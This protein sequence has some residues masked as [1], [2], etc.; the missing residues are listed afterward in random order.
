MTFKYQNANIHYTKSGTGPAVILLHG[1][2]ESTTMWEPLVSRIADKHTVIAIDFPG[3]GKSE[4]VA[5]VHTMTMMAEVVHALLQECNIDKATLIGHSM[6][7]Y[8]TLAFIDLF[9]DKAEKIILLNTTSIADSEE[10]KSVRNRSVQLVR[11]RPKAYISMA[12][13]NWAVEDSR[14][15]FKE[16]LD[17]LKNQAYTFPIEGITAALRGMRD[18]KDRTE[19]LSKF[20]KPKY[21]LLAEDDPIIDAKE[22]SKL[23]QQAGVKVKIISG[24]HMSMIENQTAL[25]DF[26]QSALED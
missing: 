11:E 3:M 4:P 19:V 5:E 18:R 10:R 20:P 22:T 15:K 13:G 24:G 2:L 26:V 7:G 17:F 23:A 21:L 6:G 12:I 8:I 9:E 25:L 14:E 1:F 16:D